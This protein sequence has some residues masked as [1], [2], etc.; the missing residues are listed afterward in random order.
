MDKGYEVDELVAYFGAFELVRAERTR[1]ARLVLAAIM[2]SP[3]R[4]EADDRHPSVVC[5]A[6]VAYADELLFTLARSPVLS[7]KKREAFRDA[8]EAEAVEAAERATGR[9]NAAALAPR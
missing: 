4:D 7:F 8:S 9:K 1:I 2:G 5:A 3:E 6:A